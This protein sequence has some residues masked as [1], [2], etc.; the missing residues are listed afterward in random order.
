MMDKTKAAK[1]LMALCEKSLRENEYN[2][3]K[4]KGIRCSHSDVETVMLYTETF[5]NTGSFAGLM[6]PHGE[7]GAVLQKAGLMA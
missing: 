1:N 4:V 5:L 6:K 2:I 3:R 7:V